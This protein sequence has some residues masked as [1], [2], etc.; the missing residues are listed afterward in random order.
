L[1][2]QLMIFMNAPSGCAP[3]CPCTARLNCGA[4]PNVCA[5][6]QLWHSTTHSAKATSGLFLISAMESSTLLPGNPAL[7]MNAARRYDEL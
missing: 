7:S 6:T 5:T 2:T 1:P 4:E 3:V